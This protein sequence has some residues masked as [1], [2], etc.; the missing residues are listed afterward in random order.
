MLA[1]FASAVK[2]P[3]SP[4]IARA[5]H[6]LTDEFNTTQHTCPAT[7]APSPTKSAPHELQ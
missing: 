7:T 6:L 1:L 4:R 3:D 5:R 2:H